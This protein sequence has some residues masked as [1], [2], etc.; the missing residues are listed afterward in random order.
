MSKDYYEIL[1]LDKKASKDEVKKAFHKLA[2]KYHPDKTGGDD[3]KFKEINEAYQ[4]LSDDS[5]RSQ[6]DTYGQTFNG[7]GGGGPGGF[8]GFEGF[9]FSGFQNGSGQGGVEFDL[10]DIFSEFFGGGRSQGRRGRDISVDIQITF[11]ESVFGTE[12]KVLINKIAE[13][14]TCRG[15]GAAVGVK[16]KKCQTCDGKGIIREARRSF[17]GQVMTNKEC[18]TCH[19]KGEIPEK[20]CATCGGEGVIKKNTEVKLDIPAGIENGEMIRLSGQGEAI[21]GGATG[22][23]YVKIHVDK[24]PTFTREG[25][26]LLLNLNIKF[27]DAITG[28][29][30][31]IETLDGKLTIKVP[32]GV[33]SGEILRIKGEGVPY[34]G[35]KRGDL[36]V[37]IIVKTP[38]KLSK[39]A[40]QLIDELKGEGI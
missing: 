12:R 7:G 33:S 10:G 8:G 36:Y 4:T 16:T 19:G 29:D 26:N 22:D 32:E 28:A 24:H 13:C 30:Y 20:A 2:H 23:L 39:K 15:S 18:P 34:K 25:A 35:A 14:D 27:T 17:L 9:D 3:V 1:G 21:S 37:K 6:Y 40:R 5:K 38:T 11:K 31:P